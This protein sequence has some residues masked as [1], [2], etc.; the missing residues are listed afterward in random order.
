MEL[1]P[2][3]LGQIIA[4]DTA[5]SCF[6]SN[7]EANADSETQDIDRARCAIRHEIQYRQPLSTN[8]WMHQR[9]PG[10]DTFSWV[11]R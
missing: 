10:S 2:A 11:K 7:G 1:P 8:E 9:L 3:S 6:T 4:G 5:D